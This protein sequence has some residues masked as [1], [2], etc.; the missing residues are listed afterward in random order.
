VRSLRRHLPARP[1]GA[2]LVRPSL[3]RKT[4][5]AIVVSVLAFAVLAGARRQAICRRKTRNPSM[6]L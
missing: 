2:V 5:T 1:F 3:G 6:A 4:P